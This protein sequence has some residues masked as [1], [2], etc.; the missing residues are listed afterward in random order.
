MKI[1]FFIVNIFFSLLLLQMR[2]IFF[3]FTIGC[4]KTLN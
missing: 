3:I 4:L 1:F 2:K